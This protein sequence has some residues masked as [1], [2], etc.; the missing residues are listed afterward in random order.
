MASEFIGGLTERP[1][2]RAKVWKNRV[3]TW[4][5]SCVSSVIDWM[6]FFFMFSLSLDARVAR[7][8]RRASFWARQWSKMTGY[9]WVMYT[10]S[11][12][13]YNCGDTAVTCMTKPVCWLWSSQLCTVHTSNVWVSVLCHEPRQASQNHCSSFEKPDLTVVRGHQ[14]GAN[15]HQIAPQGPRVAVSK[16]VFYSAA[17]ILWSQK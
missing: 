14:H 9:T 3:L 12:R 8:G 10:C 13:L 2:S 5:K 7:V 17:I 6:L 16:V 1:H 4:L 15:R 11:V